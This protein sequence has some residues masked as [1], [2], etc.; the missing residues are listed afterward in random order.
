M[1]SSQTEI[2][3][4]LNPAGCPQNGLDVRRLFRQ[5]SKLVCVVKSLGVDGV[6]LR[7]AL[8]LSS[9]GSSGVTQNRLVG[10]TSKPAS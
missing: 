2:E 3:G 1:R 7:V 5:F 4:T 8:F 6:N 9:N 10:V